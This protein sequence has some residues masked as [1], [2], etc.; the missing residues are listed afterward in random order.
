MSWCCLPSVPCV[1]RSELTLRDCTLVVAQCLKCS[2]L[3]ANTKNPLLQMM[4]PL[5]GL[6]LCLSRVDST[7]GRTL[8]A[9][10]RWL[11]TASSSAQ[12]TLAPPHSH[13]PPAFI[14]P[15]KWVSLLSLLVN[16]DFLLWNQFI[17][18][19][20]SKLYLVTFCQTSKHCLLA[21]IKCSLGRF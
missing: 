7:S 3:V 9:H 13:H 1:G 10:S 16:I 15:F 11:E 6:T 4:R 17:G 8:N 21:H 14:C 20:I 2:Q 12:K 19:D 18:C 5:W